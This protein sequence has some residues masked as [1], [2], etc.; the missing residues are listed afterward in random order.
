MNTSKKIIIL[1]LS[2]LLLALIAL[3]PGSEG[4]ETKETRTVGRVIDGDTIETS[5]GE[6]VR[7]LGIN[8]PERGE[9]YG[10]EAT[11]ELRRMLQNKQI[12][13]EFDE[14]KEDRYARLL[15]YVY[16]NEEMVNEHMVKSGLALVQIIPPNEKYEGRLM[17][18]EIDA[19]DNCRGLWEGLCVKGEQAR[20]CVTIDEIH[21][22]APG[23]DNQNLNGEWIRFGNTC[24]HDVPLDG[25]LLKDRSASNNYFFKNTTI[26]GNGTITL[27][28]GCGEDTQDKIYWQCP[29]KNFSIWNNDTDDAYLY[30]KKGNLSVHF[31]Y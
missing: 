3:L 6:R 28:S 1:T 19:Q 9:P 22:D 16:V 12:E 4:Q 5:F 10:E 23:N 17:E 15:A 7:L 11:N 21:A 8:T 14:E 13:L 27:Y 18:A 20:A 25:Y 29:E 30:D 24:S 26:E 31:G 2:S